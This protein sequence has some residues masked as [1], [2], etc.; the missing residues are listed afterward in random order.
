MPDAP[1]Y[2]WPQLIRDALGVLQ[3][4]VLAY[5]AGQSHEHGNQIQAVQTQVD[6]KAEEITTKQDHA[7]KTATEVKRAL[8]DQEK[9]ATRARGVQLYSAW[10]YL[11]D[12]AAATGDKKDADAA[13]EA[14]KAYAEHLKKYDHGK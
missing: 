1:P 6:Q 9:D 12:V 10:K 5:L 3:V 13:T 11:E 14:K 7:S 4:I 2:N 8:A